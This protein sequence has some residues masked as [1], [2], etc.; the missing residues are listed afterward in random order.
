MA[1]GNNKK[2][3]G[4]QLYSLRQTIGKDPK[5]VLKRVADFGYTEL[6]AY[7]YRDG[8]I[9]GMPYDEFCQYSKKLGMR[10]VSGHYGLDQITGD[11]WSRAVDD[12]KK[13]GMEYMVVPYIA[14]P[15]RK[16][17]DDYKWICENLNKAG[18]VCNAKGI[19][20]GYHNHAFEFETLEGQIPFDVMLTEL[21]PKNVGWELDI[22]WIVNAG[23]DPIEYFK[24]HPG[25]F[26][27]WHVKD[28]DKADRNRNADVGTGTIDYKPIFAQASLSGM[29]HF[30]V[31]QETYPGEPI[32]SI[33]NCI[34][35]LKTIL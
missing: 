7:S 2:G 35:Y 6:E 1:A 18:E 31:E 22:F 14:E 21:D 8:K 28:M 20:F 3:I 24:K 32:D 29:K 25:R 12:A 15:Q 23:H 19:R 34:K 9:F 30:Y 16:S 4:L 26:E 27:Q 33:E 10:V 5:G 11:T 17:I 13:N